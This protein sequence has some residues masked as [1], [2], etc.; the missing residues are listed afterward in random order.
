MSFTEVLGLI[1]LFGMVAVIFIG[2]PIS[3]TLLFLALIFGGVGL[4]WEQTFNLAYLQ[5]WGTMK[6]EIFP[7]VPLFIF[8]GY[9]TEQAGLM[10]RLFGALRSLLASLRG[11]LYLAVILTAT[12][13]AMATGIVGAAVTVLGIMAAPVMMKAGYDA[14]LAAGAIA[15]GGTLGVLVPPSVMLVVMGPVMGIPV[16]LLYSAA[17]GP[18]FLL[19]GCYTIYT[20]T[21]SFINPK[22][23][24]AMTME[25]RQSAYDA[26]TTE[27][28]GAPV[29]GLGLFCLVAIAYLVLDPLL[30]RVGV[31]RVPV[32]MGPFEISALAAILAL[33]SAFPYFRNA[34]FRA[35]VIGIAPLSALIGFTLGTIVGGLATPT[36]AASCGAFGAALLALLYGRLGITSLTNAA[37]GTMVTS[38]MVL[39]LAVASNVFGAVFTK[40]GTANVITNSLVALPLADWWKLALIMAIIFVLGWPFEWPV[41]IFVFLPIFLPVIEKLQFGLRKLDLLIWFG[42]LTAVNLQTAFLSPPVAMSAYYLRNVVP[43]WSLAT[44]YKGMADYMVIQVIVLI[45]LMLFPPIALWLPSVLR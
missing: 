26:M 15:A 16:N 45:L 27:K 38:A 9:M 19:A 39:F 34:Y 12:I 3:F 8:M 43:Q 25:E 20:L 36:E 1:M 4:G 30:G 37:V 5:I 32:T 7:A 17:F 33:L 29:V 14:R 18:G 31:A 13:F 10:E 28:V 42:T 22:L 6:D 35:I 24:P 44:I 2:F 40:L 41:I 11:S 21:R 23:G